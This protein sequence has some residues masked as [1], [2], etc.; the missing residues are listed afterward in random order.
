M[1]PGD[2]VWHL[3]SEEKWTVAAP[4]P[5]GKEIVCCGWP[6]SIAKVKDCELAKSATDA[7]AVE[8]AL[9]VAWGR[10]DLRASWARAWLE[11]KGKTNGKA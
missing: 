3:P 4:S 8:F 7:E 1:K 5:N 11:K 10:T 6:E 2:V 9:E